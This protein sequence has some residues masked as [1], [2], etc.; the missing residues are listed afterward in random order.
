VRAFIV[1]VQILQNHQSGRDTHVR[2]CK[3]LGPRAHDE[4]ISITRSD[5]MQAFNRGDIIFDYCLR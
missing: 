3:V 1:Q 5:L 4:N 2:A